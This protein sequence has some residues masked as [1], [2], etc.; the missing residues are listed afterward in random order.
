MFASRP[1]MTPPHRALQPNALSLEPITAPVRLERRA[2]RYLF[3]HTH[4]PT[5]THFCTLIFPSLRLGRW[6]GFDAG[7]PFFLARKWFSCRCFSSEV[8]LDI[9]RRF[10]GSYAS[11]CAP[12]DFLLDFLVCD[13]K[14]TGEGR[15]AEGRWPGETQRFFCLN[16]GELFSIKTVL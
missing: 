5:F 10:A 15:G 9:F 13:R 2:L 11:M 1:I 4:T 14:K 8:D 16:T 7:A 6:R 12:S 3:R